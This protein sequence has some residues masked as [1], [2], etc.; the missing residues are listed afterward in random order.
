MAAYN[1]RIAGIT[2]EIDGNTTKLNNALKDVDKQLGTTKSALKDVNNLLKLDP[3]NTVLVEQKQKLLKKAIDETKDRL[4]QLKSVEKDS[5]DPEQWD[6]LQREIVATEKDLESLETEYGT[7]QTTAT[8]ASSTIATKLGEVGEKL[9]DIGTKMTTV[10]KDLTTKVTLPIVG[11][12]TVA[13]KK[14]AEVDKTMTLVNQTM[15]NSEDEANL[16]NKAMSKAAANSTFGMSDAATA[17][18]N[19]AR[20]GLKAEEAADTLA[21]AMNLAAGEG[22][23]LD[24]VSQGLVSTI[25]GFGDKFSNA[26]QYADVFASACNNSALDV[27]SL[28]DSMG[29]AAPIFRTAGYNVKDAALYMGIMADNG[30]DAN[31]SSKA[32][33]TGLARL[34]KPPKEAAEALDD[35]GVEVFNADGSMKSS[36]EVQKILHKS[37]ETLSEKEKMA[38]ASAIFGKN[39]MAPWLSLINTAPEDVSNLSNALET[40]EGTTTAMAD[41]MMSGFGG[42]IEKLKSSLDVLMTTLGSLAAQYLQPVIDKLQKATEW[43]L[44]LDKSQQDMIVK[45]AAVMAAAGPLLIFIGKVSTGLG[46][47]LGVVSKVSKAITAAGGL[48]A[49]LTGLAGGFN[50]VVLAIGAAIVAGVLIIK[51]W[52]KIKAAAK[53]VVD[54]VAKKWQSLGKALGKVWD[55]VKKGAETAWNGVKTAATNGWNAVKSGV[56][57]AWTGIKNAV[58]TAASKIGPAVKEKLAAAKTAVSTTWTNIKSA[59]SGAWA[60]IKSTVSTAVSKIGPAV[61]E[62]MAAAKTAVSTTWTNI[63]SAV[64]GAWSGI[65]TAV[66]TAAGSVKTAL[67]GKMSQMKTAVGNAWANIKKAVPGAWNGI[68]SA[69][70]TAA[71]SVGTTIKN[72]FTGQNGIVTK[73]SSAWSKIKSNATGALSS[74]KGTVSKIVSAVKSI[75]FGNPFS[76]LAQKARE[77]IGTIKRLFNIRL[78]FPKFKLPH[79]S[80]SGKFKLNP[81]QVPQF[82]ISWYKKAYDDPFMFTRPTVLQTPVGAKGFGD[83]KGGEIVYGHDKLM[84]DIAA[85][86]GG[87]TINV[88]ASEGMSTAQLAREVESKLVAWQRQQERAWA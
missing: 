69:V 76:S 27:D 14:F 9:K 72:V 11:A 71:T 56:S 53:K 81:P 60:G 3:N 54:F 79:L 61:K 47:V 25:N 21:P 10:G 31:K 8:T 6:A 20:A 78:E 48:K 32:L 70:K 15:G 51:N 49:A 5:V 2:I 12:G 66:S 42:S 74:I 83:G 24:T 80:V 41:A 18:L 30:I 88:Y 4:S 7:F 19:F 33:R 82:K 68:K 55:G 23:N 50:P 17:S 84:R 75:N 46:A 64:S 43:F 86:K 26:G 39:Q 28:S 16:L 67:S 29:T 73:I 59:V 22:G 63:K 44:S 52:D 13:V 1:R 62:K 36:I 57:G 87:V 65:K 77:V 34:A 85:A 38:A 58:S 37:F 35:L 45:I 40:C